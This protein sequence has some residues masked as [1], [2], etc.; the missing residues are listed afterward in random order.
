MLDI[1]NGFCCVEDRLQRS[2]H[3]GKLVRTL[4]K[5]SGRYGG[6]PWELAMEREGRGLI[7]GL[8]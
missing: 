3:R 5:G 2:R 6:C 4:S 8:L 7:E 1:Q